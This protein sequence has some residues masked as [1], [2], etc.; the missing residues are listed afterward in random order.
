MDYN[1][2]QR[3][4]DGKLNF[5]TQIYSD[6]EDF[7]SSYHGGIRHFDGLNSET[8][9]WLIENSFADPRECQNDAPIID[10]IAAFM[11]KHPE[12]TAHGYAVDKGRDD[13]R[14]SLEG[15]DYSGKVTSSLTAAFVDL[16]G[17]ADELTVNEVSLSCWFD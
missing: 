8:L 3:E 9:D 16:F 10:D 2:N 13:Y 1:M 14:P 17:H 12:F 4:R 6:G 15:V 11:R 5:P 7:N